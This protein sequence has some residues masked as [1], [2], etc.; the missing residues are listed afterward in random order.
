MK[1]IFTALFIL[2]LLIAV[3][4]FAA[5]KTIENAVL[6]ISLPDG[7]KVVDENNAGDG[8]YSYNNTDD[9]A[10]I[11]VMVKSASG[12]TSKEF[13]EK[14]AAEYKDTKAEDNGDGF[15]KFIALT[16]DGTEVRNLLG[17]IGGNGVMVTVIGAD[18]DM[19]TVAASLA[20][21]LQ[22][23]PDVKTLF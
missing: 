23:R 21:K 17:V 10:A 18:P 13:A 8:I 4:A 2:S 12:L 9:S 5:V 3:P 20:I 7:W 19:L 14:V 6:S 16:D 22:I 11:V 1:R 15:Y